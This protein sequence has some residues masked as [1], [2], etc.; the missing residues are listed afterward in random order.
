MKVFKRNDKVV[1]PLGL[2]M[3][4]VEDSVADSEVVEC[5]VQVHG[6]NGQPKWAR[7]SA[8]KQVLQLVEEAK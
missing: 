5:L 1:T 6:S 3:I 4:V 2:Q 8:N 7:T